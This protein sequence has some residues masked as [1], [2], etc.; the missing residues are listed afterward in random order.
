MKSALASGL[1]WVPRVLLFSG[2]L[3]CPVLIKML[4]YLLVLKSD[5][6]EDFAQSI[7]TLWLMAKPRVASLS[8]WQGHLSDRTNQSRFIWLRKLKF[9][10]CDNTPFNIT[11]Y[12]R[13]KWFKLNCSLS[14][15]NPS[16]VVHYVCVY[17][18]VHTCMC[19]CARMC[20]Y[21]LCIHFTN[22][23]AYK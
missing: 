6:C 23:W 17:V 9:S 4:I 14:R 5:T 15:Q 19:M 3:N 22:L 10:L 2:T 7:Q 12:V 18:W 8:L 1:V 20:L 11:R 13:L 21:I 16:S